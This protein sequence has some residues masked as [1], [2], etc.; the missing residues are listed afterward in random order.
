MS[1]EAVIRHCS[2]TLAGMKTGNI[3][4][5]HYSDRTEMLDSIR[6]WNKKLR[7]KGIRVI[8]LRYS[9]GDTMIYLYRPSMLKHDI[10]N[11]EA[12]S[13][14]RER[15]YC[16]GNCD[17]CIEHL[18]QRLSESGEFPHEIGLFLGY[19]PED[20]DGFIK[21][22]A[23]DYKCVGYWKVYGDRERAQ[24][25]FS[26]FRKCTEVYIDQWLK[27]KSIERLIVTG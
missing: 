23:C 20:V 9:H 10:E 24:K 21:N 14:L 26:R 27:G 3:F 22:K 16:T 18:I 7:D 25:L 11:H 13:I 8:P 17:G 2:P 1:E 5:Y 6:E 12:Y 19:P 15:G 4:N